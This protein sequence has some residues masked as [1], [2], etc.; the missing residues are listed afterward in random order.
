MTTA[1]TV[2]A[3]RPCDGL[4]ITNVV[5]RAYADV[6]YSDHREHLMI[7]RLRESDGYIPTLSLLAEKEGEAIGHVLLTKAHIR[8]DHSTVTTLALAPLSVVPEFQRQG[9]GKYLI[10]LAHERAS[11]LG[12]GTVL[13]VG[14]PTYYPRFGY[15]RLSRYPIE[16]PFEAPDENCFILQLQPG[17]LNG[18]S[19]RV[20]YAQAWLDH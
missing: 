6:S 15:E 7:D 10:G 12:F 1:I 20:E 4:T 2:R 17:A 18:V 19:G 9:V 13:I 16:L 8:N 14:I 11:S 3:E 5:K